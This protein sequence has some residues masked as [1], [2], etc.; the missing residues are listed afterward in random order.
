[1]RQVFRGL[2]VTCIDFESSIAAYPI[3]VT[4]G[5]LCK[6]ARLAEPP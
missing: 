1:M 2:V 3:P 5:R 6:L 4:L